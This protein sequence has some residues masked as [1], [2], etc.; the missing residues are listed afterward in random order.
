MRKRDVSVVRRSFLPQCKFTILE[1][2]SKFRK[3]CNPDEIRVGFMV[4]VKV[5]IRVRVGV[6]V[7]FNVRIRVRVRGKEGVG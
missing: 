4:M 6:R 1:I 7:R 3:V 5:S 2:L